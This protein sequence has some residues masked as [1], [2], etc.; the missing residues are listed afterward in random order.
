[1]LSQGVEE[2]LRGYEIGGSSHGAEAKLAAQHRLMPLPAWRAG[3][4]PHE[5]WRTSAWGG[6]GPTSSHHAS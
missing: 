3:A 2:R 1:M 5:N 6:G 4:E